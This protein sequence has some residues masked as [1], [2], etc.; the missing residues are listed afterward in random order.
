MEGVE[1]G[2]IIRLA[3]DSYLGGCAEKTGEWQG[4]YGK[5]ESRETQ[6]LGQGGSRGGG[7][8]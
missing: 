7:D 8:R 6:W 1:Q 3:L 4:E 5:K 2:S